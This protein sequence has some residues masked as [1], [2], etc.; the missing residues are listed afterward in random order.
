VLKFKGTVFATGFFLS[1]AAADAAA[2]AAPGIC[3]VAGTC[4]EAFFQCVYVNCPKYFSARCSGACRARFN[5]CMRTGEFGGRD[6]RGKTL[7]RK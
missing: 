1:A 5:G 6:C 4:S 7:V 2:Q 3:T